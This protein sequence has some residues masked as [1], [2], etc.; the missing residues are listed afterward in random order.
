MGRPMAR[1]R[2]GALPGLLKLRGFQIVI[3]KNVMIFLVGSLWP[4]NQVAPI[5]SQSYDVYC[6]INKTNNNN[7]CT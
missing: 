2:I 3:K 5:G 7:D 4:P 6:E 1:Y